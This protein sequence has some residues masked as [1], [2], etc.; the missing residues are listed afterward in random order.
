MSSSAREATIPIL[1]G[2][3]NRAVQQNVFIDFDLIFETSE[4]IRSPELNRT[5]RCMHDLQG[6]FPKPRITEIDPRELGAMMY[7]TEKD[8][9]VS[10]RM[11]G[12]WRFD[13]RRPESKG[14]A[15]AGE[16]AIERETSGGLAMRLVPSEATSRAASDNVQWGISEI[17]AGGRFPEE[18]LYE[19]FIEETASWRISPQSHDHLDSEERRPRKNSYTIGKVLWDDP[20]GPWGFPFTDNGVLREMRRCCPECAMLAEII[21][22]RWSFPF[23]EPFVWR[24]WRDRHHRCRNRVSTF[25]G[26]RPLAFVTNDAHGFVSIQGLGNR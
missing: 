17:L 12:N 22:R 6:E 4:G 16:A 1:T 5:I 21:E 14:E 2:L 25:R 23:D 20:F 10:E 24:H 11:V 3:L 26:E 15:I 8:T 7:R 18:L 19:L 9:N 13:L